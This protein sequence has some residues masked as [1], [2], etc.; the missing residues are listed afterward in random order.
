MRYSEPGNPAEHSKRQNSI[1][2]FSKKTRDLVVAA[3]LAVLSFYLGYR[4][5][6]ENS[7]KGHFYQEHF[8]L[9]VALACG[10]GFV[11]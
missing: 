5:F 11:D 9:A 2:T 6:H 10:K 4:H 7:L 1:N 8:W 3:L